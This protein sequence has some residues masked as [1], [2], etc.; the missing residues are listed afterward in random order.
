MVE[1]YPKLKACRRA[2]RQFETHSCCAHSY[3]QNAK[4][5]YKEC[6]IL[7][8]ETRKISTRGAKNA[9]ELILILGLILNAKSRK[10][11]K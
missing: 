10:A 1:V 4:D 3:M 5:Q 8:E 9:N 2:S 11:N 7:F 6:E